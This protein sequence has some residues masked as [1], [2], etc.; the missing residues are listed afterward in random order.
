MSPE[1]IQG[2]PLDGRS[3]LYSMGAIIFQTL[4]GRLPFEAD[5]AV[6]LAMKHLTEPVPNIL[7]LRPEL[8]PYIQMVIMRVMAKQRGERYKTAAELA[9]ALEMAIAA[10]MTRPQEPA[11]P[12]IAIPRQPTLIQQPAPVTRVAPPPPATLAPA[13][14]VA[15]PAPSGRSRLWLTGALVLLLLVCCVG[16]SAAGYSAYQSGNLLSFLATATSQPVAEA[17]ET[18]P[19]PTATNSPTAKAT[20]I[21]EGATAAPLVPT[22]PAP[23]TSPEASETAVAAPTLRSTSTATPTETPTTT[24]SPTPTRTPSPT[25]AATSPPSGGS[26][27][28]LPLT[29]ESFGTWGRGSEANGTFEQSSEQAHGGGR[30][31]KLSYSFGTADNDYVVFLQTNNISGNPTTLELWVYGDGAGH[32]LNVWIVD[33]EGQTWQVPLGRVT[34]SGWSLMSGQIAVGQN[35]PWT[36]ISGPNNEAVDYPIRFRAFVLDDLANDYVGDGVIYLDDL[37]VR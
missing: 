3:D 6:G 25:A 29:F 30:S 16:G 5:T 28:G 2:F 24:P 11:A 37:S 7:E 18:S 14:A 17:T 35:W 15:P 9:Q 32:Y 13:K 8:P 33:N 20:E 21:I 26:G 36:H 22:T 31:G 4:S 23:G 1:Q 10:P 27:G 19:P 34:H 12:T